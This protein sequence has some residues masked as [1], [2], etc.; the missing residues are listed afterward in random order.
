MT[1]A[2]PRFPH[3]VIRA[4][5][6]TGKTFQLSNRFIGLA[7]AGAAPDQILAATFARKAA[8]EI[9]DRVLL[10]L[11][12]GALDDGKLTE[13]AAHVG[14]PELDRAHCLGLLQRLV[15]QLHRLR[16]GTL[17]RFFLQMAGGFS[18]ELGL[19]AGWAIVDELVDQK[20]RFEAIREVLQ[21]ESTADLLTLMHLLSKGEAT[22]SVTTQIADIVDELYDLYCQSPPEAWSALP[23]P[24]PL[25][26]SELEDAVAGLRALKPFTNKS[27]AKAHAGQLQQAENQDCDWEEFID[28]GLAKAILAGMETYYRV[29]I[30]PEVVAAYRPFLEHARAV[31]MGQLANQT[32]ATLR[33]LEK[34]DAAYQRL[35]RQRR[36]LR[37]DDVTVTLARWLRAERM[38]EVAYRLDAHVKHLLLDEFQD[39]SLMQ[40]S[41]MR[42][43]AE[44]VTQ[45]G[46]SESF[47]CVGDVKQ[48]IY[49]WRGG[50]SEIFDTVGEQLSGITDQA[51]NKSFRSSPAIID[52]VNRCF[53]NL[54]ANRALDSFPEAV[55]TWA[56]RFR[57]PH[58]TAKER[59]PGYCRLL[60]APRANP[61][62]D[63]S[64]V[65]LRYAAAEI[66]RIAR[67]SPGRSIGV[68]V[69]RNRAVGRL[70]YEL[71]SRQKVMAS[72][73]GGNPLTDSLAVQGILSL[74][75]IA[76]HPGHTV[77]RF[78]VASSPLG[79]IVGLARHDD[80]AAAA[81]VSRTIREALLSQG[82]GR[83]IYDWVRQLAPACDAREV[84]R[85]SQ[86]V[87]L[88]YSYEE[89]ATLR[90]DDFIEFVE[91]TR[92][93]D[94]T[95][96]DVRVM[97]VHQAK[98]L[99]FDIVVLP[100]LDVEL[101]GMP[102]RVVVGRSR[103]TDP[104]D[105]ICRYANETV[106]SI[107][108]AEYRQLFD[109]W[110][111]QA[112]SDSLCLLYVALTRAVHA[113]YLVIAPAAE[114]EK[115]WP[116]TFAGVLRSALAPANPAPPEE[117]LFEHGR[118]D[119]HVLAPLADAA[120]AADAAPV[121]GAP[122]HEPVVET[123]QV[124]MRA[125]APRK[126]R[127]L[128]RRSPSGLEGG[129]L[130]DLKLRMRLDSAQFTERGTLFHA[131]FEQIDWVDEE[132]P[133]DETLRRVGRRFA[134]PAFDIESEIVKFRQML[135]APAIY[136]ALSRATYTDPE[137]LGFV[138]EACA[139]IR[140][141]PCDLK[142]WRER[143]F[144]IRDGA[145]LL[146]G[147]I[148]RVV[149]LCQDGAPIAADVLDFKTD[150]APDAAAQ[151]AKLEYYRP[152]LE[153]Y[154]RTVC[155]LTGLAPE[156]TRARLLFVGHG[157][158]RAVE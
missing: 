92:V 55:A 37:F 25:T 156:R 36:G 28:K 30:E 74:L 10:R 138:K 89:G 114:N 85:L 91:S 73:E 16:I 136:A 35:K 96:A 118:A 152:Q 21:T 155:R 39:T 113:L 127:G 27:V 6:G 41:V 7:A 111:S 142:L 19:P 15:R 120:D 50:V 1:P 22:R 17:D 149:L 140:A 3:V 115:T 134:G 80:D 20:L 117:V 38:H 82:Y 76:D 43:L 53:E 61:S 45:P 128:E 64:T 29:P 146:T 44:Q 125:A 132:I 58:T 78:H 105:R 5:A 109:R 144:A 12:D 102:P 9:L 62:E 47:F 88:S 79:A 33:L 129:T 34:F 23:R 75:R 87:E 67:E 63:K 147:A 104:A 14:G 130:V 154:R 57:E 65:T 139:Q 124:Q 103:P 56:P 69:R 46:G 143:K 106:Q 97:T 32:E 8:G 119:W 51:L 141:Q 18:L 70:I 31:L 60:T 108:P 48:A 101:K 98:G 93:E 94:P 151:T 126:T 121:S 49:G 157:V 24:K 95:A 66:A 145:S 11:A 84:S 90:A 133:D 40:W 71:R 13:L 153:A 158:I 52:V 100:E 72:E 148:D 42:A 68:L 137:Q 83:T 150:F 86:L 116:K 2:R 131:W 26:D 110:P 135:A 81:R 59:L 4:S 107:L 54:A 122:P 112:V 99:E 77:A 123:V